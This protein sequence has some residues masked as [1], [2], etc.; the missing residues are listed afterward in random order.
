[1]KN[2]DRICSSLWNLLIIV[3]AQLL[4]SLTIHILNTYMIIK[5]MTI[6]TGNFYSVLFSP[7]LTC[8][9]NSLRLGILICKGRF[10][11]PSS[12]HV[13]ADFSRYHY[14]ANSGFV[15]INA[16][17][18]NGHG[19]SILLIS[20]LSVLIVL[21]VVAAILVAVHTKA[22]DGRS[23]VSFHF[24]SCLLV[25]TSRLLV[26][27]SQTLSSSARLLALRIDCCQF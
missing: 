20:S 6:R 19:E 13:L 8:A 9:T 12:H 22:T 4:Y 7:A 17:H 14:V 5:K 23:K 10:L 1:M 11:S 3:E 15:V 16:A 26:S 21:L 25:S 27:W 2:Y 18:N 24:Q